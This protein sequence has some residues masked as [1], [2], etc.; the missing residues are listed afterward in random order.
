VSP[1]AEPG[2]LDDPEAIA[3]VDRGGMLAV[4]AGTGRHL[5]QGLAAGRAVEGPW[6]GLRSVVVCGM[7]G[8]GVAGDLVR[9]LLGAELPVPLVVVKGYALPGF[10]GPD[11]LVVAVSYSGDTEETLAAYGEA[12][13]RRCR[14]VAVSAG[15]E[16]AERAGRDGVPRVA[17]P[18]DAP[19]PRAAVG[20][21]TGAVL[22]VLEAA[23]VAPAVAPRAERAAVTLEELAARL[24]PERGTAENEAKSVARWLLGGTP[25]VWGSEG[26]G[27]GPALR[28]KTQLNENAKV[29]AF[30][31]VLP[32]LDHNEVEGWSPGAG[33]GHRVVVLRHPGE[34][35]RVAARVEATLASVRASGLEARAVHAEGETPFEWVLSLVMKGD[36]ASVYLAVARGVDPTP[37]PVLTGLKERLRG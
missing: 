25:V 29:P 27:E 32:E 18:P 24:G 35:P 16:L 7:G 17:L 33:S 36:F 20:H 21:L 10:C 3:R 23:G 28:W 12:L 8:S 34:H 5:L 9:S 15:G 26:V 4:V 30:H 13:A 31:A 11:T 6:A 2:V 37:V 14:V 19:V 1:P 22:G